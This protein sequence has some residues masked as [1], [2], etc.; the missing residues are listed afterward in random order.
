MLKKAASMG[1]PRAQREIGKII[2]E[3]CT[4][5]LKALGEGADYYFGLA[6][7]QDDPESCF[8]LGEMYFSGKYIEHSNEKAFQLYLKGARLN[9]KSCMRRL[10]QC[11]SKGLGV[12]KNEEMGAKWLERRS[13]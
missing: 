1:S 8:H 4:D 11:Y 12:E 5:N 7:E 10:A 2:L 9:S 6:V 3:K 13:K